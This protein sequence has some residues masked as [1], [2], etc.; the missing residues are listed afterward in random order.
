MFLNVRDPEAICRPVSRGWGIAVAPVE[1]GYGR[2][3]NPVLPGP[4]GGSGPSCGLFLRPASSASPGR[5]GIPGDGELREA[6]R[7]VRVHPGLDGPLAAP[8]SPDPSPL[9]EETA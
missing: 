1:T 8:E 9:P 7:D 5:S 4:F 6:D 3:I 2:A